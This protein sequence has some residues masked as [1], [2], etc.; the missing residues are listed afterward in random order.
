MAKGRMTKTAR[1]SY[2]SKRRSTVKKPY[3]DSRYGNDAFIRVEAIEPIATGIGN[4][5]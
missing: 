4:N 5:S 2:P 3:G 1:K